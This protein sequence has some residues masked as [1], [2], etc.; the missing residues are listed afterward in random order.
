M[1]YPNYCCDVCGKDKGE[2]NHWFAVWAINEMEFRVLPWQEAVEAS[3]LEKCQHICGE[4]CLHKRL[5]Q[6]LDINSKT[7]PASPEAV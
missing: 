7:T 5:S 3:S 4:E 1:Q 2:T 6:W